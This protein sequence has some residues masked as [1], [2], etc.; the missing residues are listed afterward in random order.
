MDE[1]IQQQPTPLEMLNDILCR[2][3][4]DRVAILA[5]G[6]DETSI[7]LL[8]SQ[9]TLAAVTT[10]LHEQ[11]VETRALTRLLSDLGALSAGA[12]PSA[13]LAPRPSTHR[14]PVPPSIENAKGRLAAIMEHRQRSGLSRKD[15]ARWVVG[16]AP[17]SLKQKLG[18]K[19]PA[20]VDSWLLRWGGDRG[21]EKGGGRSG[22]EAMRAILIATNPTEKGLSD[23]MKSLDR[24]L[25]G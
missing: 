15:A 21:S 22:Y 20:T 13:M 1:D 25:P 10:Y 18:L 4:R 8:A 17:S 3:E 2:Y 9:Y 19:S 11:N 14:R 7:N 16:H 23:M 12:Q 5:T 6:E 24:S